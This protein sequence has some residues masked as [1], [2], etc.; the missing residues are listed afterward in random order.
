MTNQAA[1]TGPCAGIRVIDASTIVAGP[2][3]SQILADLG[4]EVIKLESATGDVMRFSPPAYKG[5]TTYYTQVNRGKKSFEVNLKDAAD[6]AR[7]HELVKI[8]DVFLENS[9]PGVMDRLG[10]G[11]ETLKAI[12]DRLIYVSV[13]GF[14]DGNPSSGRPAYDNVIQGLVGYMPEQGRELGA[15]AILNPA[16]DKITAIWAANSTLAALL[17]RSMTDGKGQRVVVNMTTAFAAYILP[18]CMGE[19]TFKD[20]GLANLPP[21]PVGAY[22]ALATSDG[23]VIGLILQPA[24]FQNFCDAIGRTDLKTDERFKDS[25]G[26]VYNAAT[27]YEMVADDVRK[28]TTAEFLSRM[29]EKGVP[30]GRVNTVRD[31]MNSDEARHAKSYVD[32][33]D[34]EFGPIRLLNY[35]AAF[36][37]TPAGP[38]TRAPK[39]GEHNAEILALIE[40]SK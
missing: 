8:S 38:R 13:N 5:M 39:L 37:R 30:F 6:I 34:P 28:L 40:K 21:R 23:N 24:Q 35:P 2:Y 31:F 20:S 36:E 29:N 10:L 17:H 27:L 26:L 19:H 22:N 4:A 12:N 33:E 16:A 14:G 1:N 3:G 7:V 18:E 9:R 25:M 11:Y 32:I 15:R